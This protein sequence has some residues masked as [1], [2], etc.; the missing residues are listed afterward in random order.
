MVAGAQGQAPG[1]DA[2]VLRVADYADDTRWR[3]V[4]EIPGDGEDVAG[5]FLADHAVR[6]DPGAPEYGGFLDPEGYLEHYAAPDRRAEDKPRLV[7]RLGA[8][9]GEHVLGPVGPRVLAHGTPVT[10]RVLVPEPATALL[11]RPLELAHAG[12]RPL[13]LQDVSLV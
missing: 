9:I 7:A 3:W 8:W 4:L 12:G 10:V 6:L 2:L 5:V 11:Y 1:A 13:A